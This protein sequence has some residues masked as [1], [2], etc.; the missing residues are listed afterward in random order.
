MTAMKPSMQ[1][2]QAVALHSKHLLEHLVQVLVS[3][4]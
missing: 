1:V 4:L 3:V 2:V